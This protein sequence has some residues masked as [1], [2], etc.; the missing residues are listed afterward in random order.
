MSTLVE[1][2][3]QVENISISPF[4]IKIFSLFL[5]V[6]V[7]FLSAKKFMQNPC[8]DLLSLFKWKWWNISGKYASLLINISS[9]RNSA[10]KNCF[11]LKLLCFFLELH[12]TRKKSPSWQQSSSVCRRCSCCESIPSHNVL[13]RLECKSQ[14][15]ISQFLP[16]YLAR[17]QTSFFTPK[18][19]EWLRNE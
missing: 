17:F 19:P 9:K 10:K 8:R 14:L 12:K 13:I 4:C 2:S 6:S 7:L 18:S 15:R 16:R 3:F 5:N 11:L 1:K